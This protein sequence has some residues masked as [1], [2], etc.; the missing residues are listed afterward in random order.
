M[1][2][3]TFSASYVSTTFS[4][5]SS[6]YQNLVEEAKNASMSSYSPYSKFSVG[7]AVCLKNGLD[8]SASN[9]ENVSYP[10]GIC[11]ERNVLF[12]AKSKYPDIPITSMAIAARDKHGFTDFPVS[13]CGACRQVIL[14][15]ILRDNIDFNI[16]LYGE[17]ETLIV[18]QASM[19]LPLNFHM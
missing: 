1:E 12:Y 15:T 13:P 6:T 9:Q 2:I 18:P 8:F 17:R 16:I 5:L 7:A 11:A 3:K 10:E 19:L 4:E 14:E